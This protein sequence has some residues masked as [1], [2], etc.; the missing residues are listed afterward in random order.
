MAANTMKVR[1]NGKFLIKLICLIGTIIVVVGFLLLEFLNKDNKV[2]F[3]GPILFQN[4]V[5]CV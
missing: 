3:Q 4:Q 1:Y 2:M 5:R